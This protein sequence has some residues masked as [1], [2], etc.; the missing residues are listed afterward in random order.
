[1]VCEILDKSKKI[2][3]MSITTFLS[4]FFFVFFF[5][6]FFF[7]P[8]LLSSRCLFIEIYRLIHLSSIEVCFDLFCFDLVV[9]WLV[10]WLVVW[11]VC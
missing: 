8:I 7:Y 2:I 9:G 1:M 6:L 11:C 4:F 3:P 10:G 5:F